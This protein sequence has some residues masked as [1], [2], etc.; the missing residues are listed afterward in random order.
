MKSDDFAPPVGDTRD[1]IRQQRNL[2]VVMA[3]Y[4][5]DLT[6]AA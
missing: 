1:A 4:I 6:R 3:R 2:A 5:Q